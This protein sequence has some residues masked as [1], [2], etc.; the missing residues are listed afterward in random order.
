MENLTKELYKNNLLKNSDMRISNIGWELGSIRVIKWGDTIYKDGDSSESIFLVVKGKVLLLA[1]DDNGKS[2]SVIFS[3]NDFFGAKELFSKIHRCSEA[4][5]LTDVFLIELKMSEIEFLM[6]KDDNIALNIQKGNFDFNYDS[7]T[8][9]MLREKYF[10][11]IN[12]EDIH[13]N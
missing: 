13:L 1:N 5:A 4:I 12:P 3:N 10:K 2:H 9:E 7:K 11:G 6:N 8:K